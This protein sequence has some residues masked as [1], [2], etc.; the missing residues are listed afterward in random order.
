MYLVMVA[1]DTPGW[2]VDVGEL[3]RALHDSSAVTDRLQHAYLDV[4][5]EQAVFSL[6]LQ[7]ADLQDAT[8]LADQLCRRTMAAV[9][10]SGQWSVSSTRTL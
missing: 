1:V 9:A 8:T 6:Y 5:D 7:G 10:P 4:E 3:R 2:R